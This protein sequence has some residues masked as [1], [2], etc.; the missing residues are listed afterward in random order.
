MSFLIL[1][2][3]LGAALS[4]AY[5]G[6]NLLALLVIGAGLVLIP[7]HVITAVLFI[8]LAYLIYINFGD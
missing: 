8:G 5:L 3:V 4:L 1:L 7:T 6:S 2:F